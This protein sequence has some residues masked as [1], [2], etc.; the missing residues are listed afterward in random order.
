MTHK[1]TEHGNRGRRYEVECALTY[2][3]LLVS[4]RGMD[5]SMTTFENFVFLW[6]NANIWH[7]FFLSFDFSYKCGAL[8]VGPSMA[9]CGALNVGPSM[10]SCLVASGLVL[11][12]FNWLGNFQNGKWYINGAYIPRFTMQMVHRVIRVC[13]NIANKTLFM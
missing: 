13:W 4:W 6:K 10:A 7:Q 2:C 11:V 8:N 1:E 3:V 12:Y 9:S 5:W